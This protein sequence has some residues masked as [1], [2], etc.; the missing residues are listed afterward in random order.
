MRRIVEDGATVAAN[1]L[2]VVKTRMA[3]DRHNRRL[4]VDAD[5]STDDLNCAHAAWPLMNSGV[6][7]EVRQQL[8]HVLNGRVT[9]VTAMYIKIGKADYPNTGHILPTYK[10]IRGTSKVEAVHRLSANTVGRW[11]NIR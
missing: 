7:K 11:R 5:H 1:I 3:L 6:L 9:D 8:I 2:M 10:S 4:W